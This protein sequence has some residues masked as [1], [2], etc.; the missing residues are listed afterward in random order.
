MTNYSNVQAHLRTAPTSWKR[1]VAGRSS[2]A[3]HVRVSWWI[4]YF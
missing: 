3:I 1:I 2:P 4:N